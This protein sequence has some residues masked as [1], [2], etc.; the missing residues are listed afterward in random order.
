MWR[1]AIVLFG[2]AIAACWTD[3]T[4]APAAPIGNHSAEVPRALVGDY[5]CTISESGYEYPP[6]PC[7][8]R[9][10]GRKLVLAK[11]GGSVRFEGEIRPRGEGF[12]FKGQVYCPWGDC[13]EAVAGTFEPA[14]GGALTATLG[15]D[16]MTVQLVRAD[17]GFGGTGY[18][19]N[20]YGG[21]SYGGG[22]YGGM[23]SNPTP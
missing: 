1:P 7:T 9:Q 3:R 15:Q 16:R 20:V 13:T 21:A 12:A 11:L 6:F 4:P 8:I 10:Q 5:R 19:G 23:P 14:A 2:A 17:A 22:G 18:G